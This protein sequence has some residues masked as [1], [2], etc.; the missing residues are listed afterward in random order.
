ML[1]LNVGFSRK[2]GESN[3]GSRGASVN[4]ELEAESGLAGDPDR[5]KERIRHLFGLAKASVEEELNGQSTN[6][7]TAGPAAANGNGQSKGHRQDSARRATASQARDLRAIAE[8][9]GTDLQDA[10]RRRYD[11]DQPEQLS[12]IQASELIDSLKAAGSL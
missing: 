4:L 2:T 10:L 5:L 12:I 9:Q 1:K 7:H 11:V 3:F 6:G 8:R